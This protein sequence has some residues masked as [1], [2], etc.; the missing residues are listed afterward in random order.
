MYL[1]PN[2][3]DAN[4]FDFQ[5]AVDETTATGQR[6]TWRRHENTN[7]PKPGTVVSARPDLQFPYPIGVNIGAM[8]AI[9]AAASPDDVDA[10]ATAATGWIDYAE[11]QYTDAREVWKQLE[12]GGAVSPDQLAPDR[13]SLVNGLTFG[14]LKLLAE[15][16]VTPTTSSW[17]AY[18]SSLRGLVPSM[19]VSQAIL[20]Q[21]AMRSVVWTMQSLAALGDKY[22]P[23]A[24]VDICDLARA[25]RPSPAPKCAGRDVSAG[26]DVPVPVAQPRVWTKVVATIAVGGVVGGLVAWWRRTSSV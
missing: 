13:V 26:R 20:T 14:A 23:G 8:A 12:W 24:M 21:I 3:I 19:S 11:R 18:F 16:G 22:S 9:D 25:W 7:A 17:S 10:W 1:V 6:F 4:V 5:A 15:R 2:V